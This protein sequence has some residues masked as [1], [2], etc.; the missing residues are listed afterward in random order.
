[1]ESSFI[2]ENAFRV[3]ANQ[4]CYYPEVASNSWLFSRLEMLSNLVIFSL[5]YEVGDN[6][7]TQ[8]KCALTSSYY[9]TTHFCPAICT[10]HRIYSH[11]SRQIL[12]KFL[13][14]FFSIQ[15]STQ[16]TY[17]VIIIEFLFCLILIVK[18]SMYCF[19]DN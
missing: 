16:V 10:N 5:K 9:N 4:Q 7:I 6:N 8:L 2:T 19:N 1:M 18:A 3:E 15:L 12:D 11:I 17:F 13:S 14:I